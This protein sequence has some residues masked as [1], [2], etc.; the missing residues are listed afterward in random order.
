MEFVNIISQCPRLR[1][2]HIYAG[3]TMQSPEKTLCFLT[4][5]Q[6]CDNVRTI[7]PHSDTRQTA[8]GYSLQS[9]EY[10]VTLRLDTE[11][12]PTSGSTQHKKT[13]DA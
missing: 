6:A 1:F 13:P 12:N 4:E 9:N 3:N 2:K 10:P 7:I 5:T 8:T 11:W